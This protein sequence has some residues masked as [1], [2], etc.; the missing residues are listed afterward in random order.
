MMEY[1]GS[2]AL[3]GPEIARGILESAKLFYVIT[4]R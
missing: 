1:L 3:Q 4:P 2:N